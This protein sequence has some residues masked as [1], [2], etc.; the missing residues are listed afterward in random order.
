MGQKNRKRNRTTDTMSGHDAE[1]SK[2]Y[3]GRKLGAFH[4]DPLSGEVFRE[5]V[6]CN[7]KTLITQVSS[8][9]STDNTSVVKTMRLEPFNLNDPLGGSST[10]VQPYDHDQMYAI[11]DSAIVMTVSINIKVRLNAL[12]DTVSENGFYLIAVTTPSSTADPIV[13]ETTLEA[14]AGRAPELLRHNASD[15]L[16][17]YKYVRPQAQATTG[18]PQYA[19]MRINLDACKI[20][21]NTVSQF[22]DD[23]SNVQTVG[24]APTNNPSTHLYI[25]SGDGATWSNNDDTN[26][27]VFGTIT[28]RCLFTDKKTQDLSEQ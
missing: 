26:T 2:R 19:N 23:S 21:R 9:G 17:Q 11:Y 4:M 22:L 7:L 24:F 28:H 15:A 14:K 8:I 18:R 5:H 1:H 16:I 12:K 10:T 6:N 3:K 20:Q 27:F 25:M 13:S